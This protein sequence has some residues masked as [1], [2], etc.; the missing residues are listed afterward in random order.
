MIWHPEAARGG[1]QTKGS[2][3]LAG[4]GEDEGTVRSIH[5]SLSEPGIGT[6]AP[7]ILRV[8][9]AAIAA[10]PSP[11]SPAAAAG[12]RVLER[13][14]FG[15]RR[16]GRETEERQREFGRCQIGPF[17]DFSFRYLGFRNLA[18]L[19]KDEREHLFYK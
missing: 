6:S 11:S 1:M 13:V 17:L 3:E 7:T 8:A 16:A 9:G 15:R 19:K 2:A 12:K 14:G 4:A 18:H 5:F 10:S